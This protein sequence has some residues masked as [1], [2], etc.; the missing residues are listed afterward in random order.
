VGPGGGSRL[1]GRL[2]PLSEGIGSTVFM[3]S[4]LG[5]GGGKV[6]QN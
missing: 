2:K 1:G 3:L 5:S 6:G 4:Q